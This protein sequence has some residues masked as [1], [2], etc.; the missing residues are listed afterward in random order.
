LMMAGADQA[1]A[2][3][4]TGPGTWGHMSTNDAGWPEFD[5]K[6]IN[7]LWFKKEWW[8]YRRIYHGM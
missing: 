1:D 6:Y 7:Y 2:W 5:G 4:K 3:T 8:T